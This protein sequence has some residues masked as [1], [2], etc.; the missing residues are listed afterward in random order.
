[1]SFANSS[2]GTKNIKDLLFE[3]IAQNTKALITNFNSKETKEN[4]KTLL[5]E[6]KESDKDLGQDLTDSLK[7][8]F[9][10]TAFGSIVGAIQLMP[11]ERS[12]EI[13]QKAR[14]MD[15]IS[16]KQA[17][18]LVIASIIEDPQAARSFVTN[19]DVV[20]RT[21]GPAD[22]DVAVLRTDHM[23]DKHQLTQLTSNIKAIFGNMRSGILSTLKGTSKQQLVLVERFFAQSRQEI[24]DGFGRV[25][26][27]GNARV[28]G[29]GFTIKDKSHVELL[30]LRDDLQ[31]GI[32]EA[33]SPEELE[34]LHTLLNMTETVI[35]IELTMTEVVAQFDGPKSVSGHLETAATQLEGTIETL[36]DLLEKLGEE[37]PASS[38]FKTLSTNDSLPENIRTALKAA[39]GG[40]VRG[41]LTPEDVTH[42]KSQVTTMKDTIFTPAKEALD[43]IQTNALGAAGRVNTL[44][45]DVTDELNALK[46]LS[47]LPELMG[48][49][50]SIGEV[51]TQVESTQNTTFI[52][53][54]E[55][56]KTPGDTPDSLSLADAKAH[57]K[58]SISALEFHPTLGNQFADLT[59]S[60]NNGTTAFTRAFIDKN[61]DQL[62]LNQRIA[63]EQ[64]ITIASAQSDPALSDTT[65]GTHL[66]KYGSRHTIVDMA[67]THTVASGSTLFADIAHDIAAAKDF[68]AANRLMYT[69]DQA[70]L[71]L[72]T[73]DATDPEL[74]NQKELVATLASAMKELEGLMSE[75]LT[76]PKTP[77][78]NSQK[79][80][81]KTMTTFLSHYIDSKVGDDNFAGVALN[82]MM[83]ASQNGTPLKNDD[84]DALF[85]LS[86]KA[87]EALS[88][89]IIE[90]GE[91]PAIS[92]AQKG[93]LSKLSEL[94]MSAKDSNEFAINL[95]DEFDTEANLTLLTD[96]FGAGALQDSM[97]TSLRQM[98]LHQEGVQLFK[99][100][101]E[102][103]SLDTFLA[104]PGGL[105]SAKLILTELKNQRSEGDSKK[106]VDMLI[107]LNTTLEVGALRSPAALPA[108]SDPVVDD[109]EM[110][111]ANK[112]LFEALE[113]K[114][115]KAIRAGFDSLGGAPASTNMFDLA[116][117]F[118]GARGK[119]ALVEALSK[120][121]HRISHEAF[122]V[123]PQHAMP[124]GKM[125]DLAPATAA[126]DIQAAA[127]EK[128]K[129]FAARVLQSKLPV[130][131]Y[132]KN[133]K[134]T[135]DALKTSIPDVLGGKAIL[136]SDGRI[137]PELS[138]SQIRAAI[139]AIV[140][141]LGSEGITVNNAKLETVLIGSQNIVSN[142]LT[143]LR[144]LA[145][146]VSDSSSLDGHS[147]NQLL[148]QI[149]DTLSHIENR[150]LSNF[151]Q[152]EAA[153][154]KAASRAAKGQVS[155]RVQLNTVLGYVFANK[156]D[157]PTE[158]I[159]SAE[160]DKLTDPTLDDDQLLENAIEILSKLKKGK[161]GDEKIQNS[162]ANSFKHLNQVKL[163]F[164]ANGNLTLSDT[165]QD[166]FLG[167][168]STTQL[169]TTF[170]TSD[171]VDTLR[172]LIKMRSG[173]TQKLKLLRDIGLMNFTEKGNEGSLKKL[174]ALGFDNHTIISF[175]S[176]PKN[177]IA[178]KPESNEALLGFMFANSG[179]DPSEVANDRQNTVALNAFL[180]H[181]PTF[182]DFSEI[183][184]LK[185]AL[186]DK[187]SERL[188][189][190]LS[191][192]SPASS[193][194]L[195]EEIVA[196]E[197][198]IYSFEANSRE[199]SDAI[200]TGEKTEIVAQ[201]VG[202]NELP[203]H[204]I[205]EDAQLFAVKQLVDSGPVGQKKM[206]TLL[207]A[208]FDDTV[209]GSNPTV[210]MKFLDNLSKTESG[211]DALKSMF[212]EFND[213]TAPLLFNTIIKHLSKM[214]ATADGLSSDLTNL[215]LKSTSFRKAAFENVGEFLPPAG[216]AGPI[217][218]RGKAVGKLI[219]AAILHRQDDASSGGSALTAQETATFS[220]L[221]SLHFAIGNKGLLTTLVQEAMDNGLT[222]DTHF[223][224]FLTTTKIGPD[225][226]SIAQEIIIQ[227][228]NGGSPA[229]GRELLNAIS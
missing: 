130:L 80:T 197:I 97:K 192:L 6:L 74:N 180:K 28:K 13:V 43:S 56:M 188:S 131:I 141:F 19:L 83:T 185:Q 29:K 99:G 66:A 73:M 36:D 160:L 67:S 101:P 47:A 70:N 20:N 10:Q 171:S 201:F 85:S 125:P 204:G 55:L 44:S 32:N 172:S 93:H 184:F 206:V 58:T 51:I 96:S 59:D 147:R 3:S 92:A 116:I 78:S 146:E 136:T 45:G 24:Q 222:T 95:G 196:A 16:S 110:L 33:T 173:D 120:Q 134:A 61:G 64:V 186:Q 219:L 174:H 100:T 216:T 132:T 213:T 179:E 22:T 11:N 108:G 165:E 86:K 211:H 212:G 190:I 114:D 71:E 156:G 39:I 135:F 199:L 8:A 177:F 217:P 25:A 21:Y 9:V 181:V 31:T 178:G 157:I 23:V 72:E 221:R 37:E 117:R 229:K 38:G 91:D 207:E 149:D 2:V 189:S 75:V 105:E 228:L 223:K 151:K 112:V 203:P 62:T 111:S 79:A 215:L 143:G 170:K 87:T 34:Q 48:V 15:T 14:A 4:V 159:S 210:A 102:R 154:E 169:K 187:N 63:L 208:L 226:V 163:Q 60:I 148:D 220:Q 205:G 68:D 162:V 140:A 18:E 40:A 106:Y 155:V 7:R 198:N 42:L 142:R 214:D 161:F 176:D 128:R 209:E 166:K 123:V 118:P 41:N 104:K 115:E 129:D 133:A 17:S 103:D 88:E 175:I 121:T 82:F 12:L 153:S 191:Q 54:S 164:V 144:R 50:G 225:S 150:Q 200:D 167:S 46:T 127:I 77:L 137:N 53:M 218:K 27:N 84:G 30:K 158:T 139:P 1:I 89:K 183:P 124:E 194:T 57:A 227:E 35:N 138:Q 195:K 81:H 94:V 26:T 193:A 152:I 52:A 145:L 168:L 69:W 98:R 49:R 122:H 65:I 126:P 119:P 202:M 182:R 224:E 76:A 109:M 5:V 90:M 113:A 107:H